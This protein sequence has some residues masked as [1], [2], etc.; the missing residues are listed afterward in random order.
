MQ[1]PAH[2]KG[3]GSNWEYWGW[4]LLACTAGKFMEEVEGGQDPQEPTSR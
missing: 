2:A 1:K 4:G 3:M